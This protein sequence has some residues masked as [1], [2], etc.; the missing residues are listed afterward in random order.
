MLAIRMQRT[1][2]KGHAMF[3]M[4]VQDSRQTPTSGRVVATLGSYDPHTKTSTLNKE[5][6]G[7]Y[8][9][10]GAQPSDRVARLLQKEGVALPGWVALSGQTAKTTRNPDKLRKN[11]PAEEKP[12]TEEAPAPVATAN[13][14]DTTDAENTAKQEAPAEEVAEKAAE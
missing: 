13:E 7:F 9:E 1:G 8:L 2:R 5:K 4:V 14:E 12:K 6:A 11:Q 3:R 10:H